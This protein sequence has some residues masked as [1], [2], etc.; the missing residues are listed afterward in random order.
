MKYW[1]INKVDALQEWVVQIGKTLIVTF[2]IFTNIRY[3]HVKLAGDE[4]TLI[5]STIRLGKTIKKSHVMSIE[6]GHKML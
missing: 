5:S 3:H 1:M 2:N 6:K 4:A